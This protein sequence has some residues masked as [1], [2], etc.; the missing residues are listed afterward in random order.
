MI[1]TPTAPS[2]LSPLAH[3][4]LPWQRWF[5]FIAMFDAV[6][7]AVYH[8]LPFQAPLSQRRP[9]RSASGRRTELSR[10]VGY[11]DPEVYAGQLNPSV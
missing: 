2:L 9:V 11:L 8:H 5:A 1:D 10:R 7:L 3:L 6:D 4:F